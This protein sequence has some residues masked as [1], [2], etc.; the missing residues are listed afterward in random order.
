MFI[1]L[2][3]SVK[4]DIEKIYSIAYKTR[5]D[6]WQQITNQQSDELKEISDAND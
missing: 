3:D 6:L 2:T 4:V 1:V 5:H